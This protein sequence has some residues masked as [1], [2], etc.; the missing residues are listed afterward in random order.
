[1]NTIMA[2]TTEVEPERFRR[3]PPA[4]LS[5]HMIAGAEVI[6]TADAH[7]LICY[8]SRLPAGL[9]YSTVAGTAFA[10][11]HGAPWVFLGMY[12]FEG[13]KQGTATLRLL[14]PVPCVDLDWCRGHE[15][16]DTAGLLE[17]E[18]HE[19]PRESIGMIKGGT[20]TAY[21]V[22]YADED[23][24]MIDRTAIFMPETFDYALSKTE[25]LE[26]ADQLE[27]LS[28]S[29]RVQARKAVQA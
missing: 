13:I 25:L 9:L 7:G 26:M 14:S 3:V 2:H 8:D 18:W 4:A 12:E 23:G 29:V 28:K 10:D 20:V 11:E 27:R 1:M 16:D 24:T 6:V 17:P 5:S 19:G 21:R 22:S 15:L